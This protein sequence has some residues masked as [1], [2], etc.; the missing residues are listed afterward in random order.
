ML[1]VQISCCFLEIDHR[2]D[3]SFERWAFCESSFG[4]RPAHCL[5]ADVGLDRLGCKNVCLSVNCLTV[6]ACV[7]IWPTFVCVC[8]CFQVVGLYRLCGS[9]AVKKELREAFERDSHSAELCENTYPDINV[10]TGKLIAVNLEHKM[11]TKLRITTHTGHLTWWL[12][13]FWFQD[14]PSLSTLLP[15]LHSGYYIIYWV[16]KTLALLETDPTGDHR[17]KLWVLIDLTCSVHLF[18]YKQKEEK[19]IV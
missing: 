16:Y 18:C 5:S 15:L 6:K 19:A 4:F 14:I 3:T 2:T 17:W 8:V 11:S 7:F 12:A 10:I 1:R 13:S 9:A